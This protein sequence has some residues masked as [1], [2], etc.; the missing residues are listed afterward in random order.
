M[1]TPM[2][3]LEHLKK[4]L[5]KHGEH[6]TQVHHLTLFDKDGPQPTVVVSALI[7]LLRY[8]YLE[9][10][11]EARVVEVVAQGRQYQGELLQL[12]QQPGGPHALE[13]EIRRMHHIH[14]VVKVVVRDARVPPHEEPNC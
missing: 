6:K 4:N 13:R 11:G 8:Y 14:R 7:A 5:I 1:A 2:K 3:S 12:R 10:V 9:R